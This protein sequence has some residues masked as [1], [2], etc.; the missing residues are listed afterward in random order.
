MEELLKLGAGVVLA[1]TEFFLIIK[2][3]DFTL[4][5]FV[6]ARLL[7]QMAVDILG[8]QGL[9]HLALLPVQ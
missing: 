5:V 2:Q 6:T 7:S 4:P 1:C 8:R 9:A 3:R